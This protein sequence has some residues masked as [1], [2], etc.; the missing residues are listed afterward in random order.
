MAVSAM[1]VLLITDWTANDGGIEVYVARAAQ[2]LRAAGHDV[3]LLTSSVSSDGPKAADYVAFGT[4]NPAAQTVLQIVNPF[5]LAGVRAAVRDFRPDVVQVNM[6][7]KYLSPGIF[8]ALRGVPTVALVHYSK[9]VCPTAL[10]LLPGGSL[11]QSPA[12]LVCWRSGCIGLAEWLRDRPRYAL[13][14]SGLSGSDKVLACSRWMAEQLRLSGIAADAIPL[15]VPPPGPGYRRAPSRE[16]LF[17]YCGR[18]EREKGIDL[19]LRAFASVVS[20]RP[21]ARLRIL[22]G[23]PRRATLEA[24]AQGLGL[25]GS[26]GFE[27]RVSFDEVERALGQAWALLAPS[28]WPEPLGLTAIEAITRGVPAIASAGGGFAETIEPGVSGSLVPNGDEGALARCLIHAVDSGPRRV[29][30]DVVRRLRSSHDPAH[31]TTLL[32]A[33]FRQVIEGRRR[34]PRGNQR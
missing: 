1:R 18:L 2:G 26:V 17:V 32:T 9:P 10:K 24:Q 12:G 25:G 34:D 19:L 23:G 5:A 30:H 7:E 22:G 15:P 13:I 29:P 20:H 4:D 33:I 27:G 3:R 14:R 6:F 8:Q 11:C 16:P 28:L 31:H 21:G